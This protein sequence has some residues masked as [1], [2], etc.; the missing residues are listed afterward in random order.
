MIFE[1]ITSAIFTFQ[2]TFLFPILKSDILLPTLMAHFNNAKFT[3]RHFIL[4]HFL[5][6]VT[7]TT[8][9][10]AGGLL[11][12]FLSDATVTDLGGH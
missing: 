7:W 8:S 6:K 1:C 10:H 11:F 2:I 5:V 3:L 9:Q 12:H 4:F